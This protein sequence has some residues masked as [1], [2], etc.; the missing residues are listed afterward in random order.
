MKKWFSMEMTKV[1]WAGIRPV[2]KELGCQY[3]ASSCGCLVHVEVYCEPGV[4][5]SI[6]DAIDN[7]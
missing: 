4:A 2:L 6:N 5:E 7:L 3:E 1:E